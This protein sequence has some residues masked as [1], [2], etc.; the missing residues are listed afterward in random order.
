MLTLCSP[1]VQWVLN[2][3]VLF[4]HLEPQKSFRKRGSFKNIRNNKNFNNVYLKT[5]ISLRYFM[6]LIV[7]KSLL[8]LGLRGPIQQKY[9]FLAC[10]ALRKPQPNNF[11]GWPCQ[12][13]AWQEDFGD[14]LSKQPLLAEG[15]QQLACWEISCVINRSSEKLRPF[16]LQQ[17]SY[18]M[19]LEKLQEIIP[20]YEELWETSRMK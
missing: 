1:P 19:R 4:Y 3:E 10:S 11:S 15:K 7:P 14:R 2:E 13:Q 17:K 20:F 9:F 16:F 6:H 5:F 8:T 18:I 12:A